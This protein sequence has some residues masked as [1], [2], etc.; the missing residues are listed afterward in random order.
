VV[1]EPMLEQAGFD[2]VSAEFDRGL[3]GAYTCIRRSAVPAADK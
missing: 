1:L 2:I 3:Y